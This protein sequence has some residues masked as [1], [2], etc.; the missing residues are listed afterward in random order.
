MELISEIFSPVQLLAWLGGALYFISY[1]KQSGDK[2]IYYWIPADILFALHFYF[3]GAPFFLIIA[4]GS[5]VRSLVALRCSRKILLIYLL[6]FVCFICA[7]FLILPTGT[8]EIFALIGTTFFTVSVW[9]KERFIV[10]RLLAF[11]HQLNWIVAHGL[12]G[13]YGGLMLMAVLFISNL[14]GTGRYLFNQR[15]KA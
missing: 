15:Y 14:I 11:V 10:H 6:F 13:S 9:M 12:L 8:K 7:S 4:F 1:L 2:T 3:M 5:I